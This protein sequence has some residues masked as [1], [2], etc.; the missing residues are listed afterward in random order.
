MDKTC[1]EILAASE[2]CFGFKIQ[3][4]KLEDN[5]IKE[6]LELLD[7]TKDIWNY[8]VKLE[9]FH[10][11]ENERFADAIHNIQLMI[12]YRITHK[13]HPEIFPSKN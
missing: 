1:E 2:K 13:E 11:D 4:T 3:P 12:S 10:P 7:K 9:K 5:G 8:F 6:E